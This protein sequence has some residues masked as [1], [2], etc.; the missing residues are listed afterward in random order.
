MG[1]RYGT[2]KWVIDVLLRGDPAEI[3]WQ[4]IGGVDAD[5]NMSVGQT[6]AA[7]EAGLKDPGRPMTVTQLA[8][9]LL[10]GLIEP[11]TKIVNHPTQPLQ[12]PGSRPSEIVGDCDG[13]GGCFMRG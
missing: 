3:A 11:G 5:A 1:W 8:K 12:E 10:A 7:E 4:G 9:A 2:P 13:P 6:L